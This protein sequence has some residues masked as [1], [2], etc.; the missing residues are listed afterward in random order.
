[1][2]RAARRQVIQ[3]NARFAQTLAGYVAATLARPS[4]SGR[5]ARLSAAEL[6]GLPCVHDVKDD[7]RV[8]ALGIFNEL[9]GKAAVGVWGVY[10]FSAE[11]VELL[12]VSVHNDLFLVT[13]D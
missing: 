13:A 8:Q 4:S 6:H 2:A 7:A 11:V 9:A 3:Q 5:M 1:M 10:A 12:E